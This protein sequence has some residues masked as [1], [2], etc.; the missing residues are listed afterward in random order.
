MI[1]G[2][3]LRLTVASRARFSTLKCSDLE[4]PRKLEKQGHPMLYTSSYTYMLYKI[5]NQADAARDMCQS[6]NT[7]EEDFSSRTSMGR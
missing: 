2:Q 1:I 5:N 3:K 7:E 4:W 6:S